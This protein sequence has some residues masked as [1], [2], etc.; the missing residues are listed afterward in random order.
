VA[1]PP[2]TPPARAV[3]IFETCNPGNTIEVRVGSGKEVV[4]VWQGERQEVDTRKAHVLEVDLPQLTRV[5]RVYCEIDNTAPRWTEIDSIAL[6]T[7]PRA[8]RED[9]SPRGAPYRGAVD[10]T[11]RQRLTRRGFDGRRLGRGKRY[12]FFDMMAH[13]WRARWRGR[14]PESARAS[15]S[16]GG[17]W[18]AGRATGSPGHYP[19]TG[20]LPGAWA[21]EGGRTVDWLELT[22]PTGPPVSAIRVFES[23]GAGATFAVTLVR[24]RGERLVWQDA[25]A[26]IAGGRVLEI[27]LPRPQRVECLC[28][29]VDGSVPGWRQIDTVGLI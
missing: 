22:Y 16:H 26:P 3:R 27:S 5:E 10:E 15:S 11:L 12:A 24:P 2:N 25:P 6:L 1:F 17:Q 21:P 28:L 19:L 9:V 18:S 4:R 23:Y 20:E 13:D 8:R 29:Y 7:V 14:W